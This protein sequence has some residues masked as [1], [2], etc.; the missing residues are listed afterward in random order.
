MNLP[1]SYQWLLKVKELPKMVAEAIKVFGTKETPGAKSNPEILRWAKV[2]GAKDYVNDGIAWCALFVAYICHLTD[3]PI[4]L[5]PLWALNWR[6][7]GIEV[8]PGDESCGDIFVKERQ[9][10]KG[11]Q[12]GGHIGIVV[13][14]DATHIHVLGGNQSDQVMIVRFPKTVKHWIRRPIYSQ[15][16]LGAKQFVVNSGGAPVS[17]KE[18]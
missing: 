6:F 14:V 3:K 7:W 16:P 10:S 12:I 11:K 2:I 18:A 5:N 9:D 4:V 15:R 13:A 8:Q 1:D 17:D